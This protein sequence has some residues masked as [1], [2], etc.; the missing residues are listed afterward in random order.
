MYKDNLPKKYF[1][2]LPKK[3]W[4]RMI[5]VDDDII[6]TAPNLSK[7]NKHN[8]YKVPEKYFNNLRTNLFKINNRKTPTRVL[9]FRWQYAAASF[10]LVLASF[11]GFKS[12]NKNATEDFKELVYEDVVDY[13]LLDNEIDNSLLLELSEDNALNDSSDEFSEISDEDLDLYIDIIIDDFTAEEIN[14]VI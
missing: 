2:A 12:L 6:N 5:S 13:Y 4:A 8:P 7:F 11:I 10:A 9:S 1:E 14:E 3:I